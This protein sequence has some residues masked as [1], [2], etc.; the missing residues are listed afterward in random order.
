M[1]H[2]TRVQK[3]TFQINLNQ[4]KDTLSYIFFQED[5]S[6]TNKTSLILINEVLCVLKR[7]T[8]RSLR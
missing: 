6:E 5:S 1:K 7:G 2:G 3:F 8:N 4:V